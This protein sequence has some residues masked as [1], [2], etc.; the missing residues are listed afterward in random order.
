MRTIVNG[1][2]RVN[3]G[4]K[5]NISWLWCPSV[6]Q[7]LLFLF[8]FVYQ[9]LHNVNWIYFVSSRKRILIFNN[10]LI[11]K[12]LPTYQSRSYKHGWK[13]S[14][15]FLNSGFWGWLSMESQPQ[16]AELDYYKFW[17]IFRLSV[18]S[19]D[20]LNFKF[21]TF[22][23]HTQILRFKFL[24]FRN[25]HHFELSPSIRLVRICL[26]SISGMGNVCPAVDW[27][28]QILVTIS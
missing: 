6:C 18:D 27:P 19:W 25:I 7:C 12:P 17:F 3:W 4:E 23:M 16:N 5:A 11:N 1:R 24:K 21:L 13:L 8:F 14:G 15:L 22:C 28:V 9:Y 20:H 26:C 10:C 2:K